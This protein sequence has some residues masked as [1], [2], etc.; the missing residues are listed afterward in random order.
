MKS[1]SSATPPQIRPQ[2]HSGGELALVEVVKGFSSGTLVLIHPQALLSRRI[3]AMRR[4][5]RVHAESST[6]QGPA[7][8]KASTLKH[9]SDEALVLRS[10]AKAAGSWNL[11]ERQPVPYRCKLFDLAAPL[12]TA[13]RVFFEVS[14]LL[15]QAASA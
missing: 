9:K 14:W 15:M 10:Y 2:G 11:Q 13:G 6:A 8:T 5:K 7:K 12:N 1:V 4:S 3:G